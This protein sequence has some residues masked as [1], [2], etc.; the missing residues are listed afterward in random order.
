[1][2]LNFGSRVE[3]N[4]YPRKN[5]SLFIVATSL[6]GVRALL[7]SG[8]VEADPLA[9]EHLGAVDIWVEAEELL[10]GQGGARRD[11]GA[12]VA[13]LHLVHRVARQYRHRLQRE[14]CNSIAAMN[15][16]VRVRVQDSYIMKLRL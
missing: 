2:Q 4:V 8:R 16:P 13:G 12:S 3:G 5:T 7:G 9:K 11:G 1:M 6:H 10:V 14:T 15:A